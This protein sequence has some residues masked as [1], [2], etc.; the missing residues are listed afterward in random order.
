[1]PNYCQTIWEAYKAVDMAHAEAAREFSNVA[2][3]GDLEFGKKL[4]SSVQE[5]LNNLQEVWD[6]SFETLPYGRKL[7]GPEYE[8]IKALF[9]NTNEFS[10]VANKLASGNISADG[11][12]IKYLAHERETK[13]YFD[14]IGNF[15]TLE[16]LRLDDVGVENIDF[17]EDMPDVKMLAFYEDNIN[18]YS[19]IDNHLK[20]Q[21]IYLPCGNFNKLDFIT[22]CPTLRILDIGRSKVED[23]SV[24]VDLPCLK[25]VY[26]SGTPVASN[27][28]QQAI[29]G[30]LREKGVEVEV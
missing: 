19:P 23:V 4:V 22:H 17:L 9:P 27:S 6:N 11:H 28:S 21:E 3:R 29:I 20:L 18:D 5:K 2:A 12:I 30:Q 8:A 13:K 1:M 16:E 7:F 24:L 25:K 10:I 14:Q 26:I 15:H